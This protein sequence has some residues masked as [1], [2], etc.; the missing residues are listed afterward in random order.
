M[1][2]VFLRYRYADKYMLLTRAGEINTNM[3]KKEELSYFLYENVKGMTGL[4]KTCALHNPNL[5]S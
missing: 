1:I 2:Q 5:F 4:L 3:V